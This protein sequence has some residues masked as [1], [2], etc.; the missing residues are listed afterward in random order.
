MRNSHKTS[1]DSSHLIQLFLLPKYFLVT[2]YYVEVKCAIKGKKYT[3]FLQDYQIRI[4]LLLIV[5]QFCI[6]NYFYV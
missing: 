2:I 4:N 1:I 5:N 3:F 6:S